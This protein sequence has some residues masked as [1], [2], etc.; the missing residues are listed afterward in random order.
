MTLTQ[1]SMA[2]FNTMTT[3]TVPNTAQETTTQVTTACKIP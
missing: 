3:L 1:Y 2:I